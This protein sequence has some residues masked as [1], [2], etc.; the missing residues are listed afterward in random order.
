MTLFEGQSFGLPT[1][2]YEMPWLPLVEGNNG[3]IAVPQGS[4]QK[5][6]D[7]IVELLNNDELR[8]E[9]SKKARENVERF[10]GFDYEGVWQSIF[11]KALKSDGIKQVPDYQAL[12]FDTFNSHFKFHISKMKKLRKPT[13]K[14]VV[15]PTEQLTEKEMIKKLEWFRTAL[16]AAQNGKK[17]PEPDY[18]AYESS[19]IKRLQNELQKCK[20]DLKKKSDDCSKLLAD[21]NFYRSELDGTR[22]SLSFRLARLITWLPRKLRD[23]LKK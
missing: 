21:A 13:D 6:A 4:K 10:A 20:A 1:V 7:A 5:A 12:M 8:L 3:I 14:I 18:A 2:M 17:V 23:L 22:R 16:S 11:D 15:S 19:E 9:M